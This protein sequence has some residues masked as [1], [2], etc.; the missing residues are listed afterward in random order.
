MSNHDLTVGWIGLG[1]MGLPMSGRLLEAGYPLTVYNRTA[2]KARCLADKG[3]KV[4]GSLQELPGH[5][6]V[7]FTMIA[8]SQAL[9]EVTLGEKGIFK[10]VKPGTIFIDMSTVSPDS[11]AKVSLAAK[12]KGVKYL[13]A[14]VTGST[15]MAVAGTLGILTSGD[16]DA[17]NKVLDVLKNLGQKVF[18][19]GTGEEARYMK[20]L[21]NIMVGIT[22]QM[23][24][25]A[26]AFGTKAGLDWD[27]MLEVLSNSAVASPLVCYKVNSL[28]KRDYSP[29]FTINLMEKDFDLTLAASKELVVPMPVTGLVKQYLAAAKA[30]GKGDLDFISLVKL[31]EEFAGIKVV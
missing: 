10:T 8:N 21:L 6:S 15:T 5:V 25:E 27:Q 11:S 29:M 7:I 22:G 14:P 3:V 1:N 23:M 18:Y 19:L 9:E 4:V 24:G 30:T 28:S 13:R 16:E 17:Y 26:L 12:D 2:E 20:M 31:A